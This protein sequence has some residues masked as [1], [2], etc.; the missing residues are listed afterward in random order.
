MNPADRLEFGQRIPSTGGYVL[1]CLLDIRPWITIDGEK[2]M[3][4]AVKNG[5][6]QRILRCMTE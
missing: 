5:G 2:T 1:A 6:L 4:H 3:E